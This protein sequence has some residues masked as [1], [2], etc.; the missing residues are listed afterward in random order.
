L[1]DNDLRGDKG[2][3]AIDSQGNIA[4]E[5]NTNVMRRAYRVGEAAPFVGIY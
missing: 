3:I 5:C 1:R 4:L 2:I